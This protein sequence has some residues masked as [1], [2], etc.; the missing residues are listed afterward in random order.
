MKPFDS[1]LESLQWCMSAPMFCQLCFALWERNHFLL[2]SF[3]V[4]SCCHCFVT[5]S[6]LS[7]PAVEKEKLA[8]R[9]QFIKAGNAIQ[10]ESK[11]LKQG[12]CLAFIAMT[13]NVWRRQNIRSLLPANIAPTNFM[14]QS[15]WKLKKPARKPWRYA[16]PKLGPTYRPTNWQAWS[17]ELLA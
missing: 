5:I 9:Y 14:S 6:S 16:S 12:I 15:F 13:Y 8:E 10:F 17:V 1:A 7:L 3:P 2:I 4:G 11:F